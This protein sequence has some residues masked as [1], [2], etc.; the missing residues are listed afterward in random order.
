MKILLHLCEQE[1]VHKEKERECVQTAVLP[2]TPV[3]ADLPASNQT[4]KL[5]WPKDMDIQGYGYIV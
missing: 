1:I 2:V 5:N 3:H 4:A